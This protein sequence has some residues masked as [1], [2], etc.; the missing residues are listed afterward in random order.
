[1]WSVSS[2]EP[3]HA[4][5]GRSLDD[6]LPWKPSESFKKLLAKR[7]ESEVNLR[8]YISSQQQKYLHLLEAMGSVKPNSQ[9]AKELHGALV[10]LQAEMEVQVHRLIYGPSSTPE[11][12]R[13]YLDTYGCTKPTKEALA[14]IASCSKRIIEIGA[15]R[16][17]WALELET[18]GIDVLAIDDFSDI[19]SNDPTSAPVTAVL[20]GTHELIP[21]NTDRTLLL[22]YPPPTSLP[23]DAVK[24]YAGKTMIYVGEPVGGANGTEAFFSELEK[25]WKVKKVV[26]LEPFEGGG[27]RLWVL[28]RK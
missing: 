9:R 12:R 17:H 3:I 11:Q 19:P 26:D 13:V 22:V 21:L 23:L 25:N 4:D 1:M 16:G 10:S 28:E 20:R 7:A 27:E 15:G 24:A 6:E 5:S 8:H 14:I 18:R 2:S